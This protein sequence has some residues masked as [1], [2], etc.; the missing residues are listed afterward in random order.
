MIYSC[1]H[2]EANAYLPASYTSFGK[3][4][5]PVDTNGCISWHVMNW[6]RDMEPWHQIGIINNAFTDWGRYLSP[7]WH[8]KGTS[9]REKAD[10]RIYFAENSTIEGKP[11]PF[12]FKKSPGTLAVQYPYYPG[13]EWSLTLIINDDHNFALKSHSYDL[14][15]V[16]RHEIGH[17]LRLGH[18]NIKGSV[19]WPE[20]QENEDFH[21]DD[22]DGLHAMHKEHMS[23]YRNLDSVQRMIKIWGIGFEKNKGCLI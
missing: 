7:F 14:Y 11:S 3:H 18:N 12:D 19:M 22:I 4:R 21:Q 10:W 16:I 6:G 9:Q 8:F 17:G 20:Y 2:I 13:F 15:K 1:N 23:E 5:L